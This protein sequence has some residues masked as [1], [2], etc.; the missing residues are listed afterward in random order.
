MTPYLI[1]DESRLDRDVF[2]GIRFQIQTETVRH[3]SIIFH[4][5]AFYR[6]RRRGHH[7]P[8]LPGKNILKIV[9]FMYSAFERIKPE[10]VITADL[11]P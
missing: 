1:H 8:E 3:E 9:I 7:T 2:H 6:W 5:I 11:K 10:L 4:I